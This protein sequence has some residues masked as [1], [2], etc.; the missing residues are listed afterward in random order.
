MYVVQI[1]YLLVQFVDF[2]VPPL[3]IPASHSSSHSDQ[4]HLVQQ[5]YKTCFTVTDY[6]F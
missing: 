6:T 5:Q 4:V 2:P 3:H 1:A